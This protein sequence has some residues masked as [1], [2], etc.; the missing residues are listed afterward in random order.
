MLPK[1]KKKKERKK[2]TWIYSIRKLLL[3][4]FSVLMVHTIL[5][6]MTE[7]FLFTVKKNSRILILKHL[8]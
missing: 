6:Q 3:F 2:G 4:D 5:L 7:K 1:K 8:L